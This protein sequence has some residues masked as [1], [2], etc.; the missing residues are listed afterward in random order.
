[1]LL[2]KNT[3]KKCNIDLHR[4]IISSPI[5]NLILEQ[6]QFGLHKISQTAIPSDLQQPDPKTK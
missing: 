4:F 3:K 1:M 6:C 5:G 2:N